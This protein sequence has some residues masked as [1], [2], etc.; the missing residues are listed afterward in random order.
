[1]RSDFGVG[2]A[3][4]WEAAA[5]FR[6]VLANHAARAFER[7]TL[8]EEDTLGLSVGRDVGRWNRRLDRKGAL[9]G[10]AAF[11]ALDPSLDIGEF[12]N[13]DLADLPIAHP[14]E[15]GD[16]G[17]RVVAG[18]EDPALQ[19]TVEDAVRGMA[20]I[21]AVVKSSKKNA[22]WTRLDV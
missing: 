8:V 16:V 9:H 17:N 6:Q 20:F 12:G 2:R 11:N 15:K 10:R 4:W 14:A 13:V 1:M 18:D 3:G 5:E 7:S 19:P 22:A 21:E